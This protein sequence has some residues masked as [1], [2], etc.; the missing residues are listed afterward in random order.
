MA[1]QFHIAFNMRTTQGWETFAKFFIGTSEEE[2]K[3]LFSL[4][5]GTADIQGDYPLTI[6]FIEMQ[7]GLPVN[8]RM[9]NCTLSQLAENTKIITKELF[10]L[11]LTKGPA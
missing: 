11:Q 7:K 5:K 3:N 10:R 4:L 9:I 2:A 8:L 6:D 1:K